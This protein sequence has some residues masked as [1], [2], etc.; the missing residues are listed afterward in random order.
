MLRKRRDIEKGETHRPSSKWT[1]AGEI[2]SEVEGGVLV[3]GVGKPFGHHGALGYLNH[4]LDLILERLGT[5]IQGERGERTL[6]NTQGRWKVDWI[7]LFGLG[8]LESLTLE[9]L[10]GELEGV[11]RDLDRLNLGKAAFLLPG[12]DPYKWCTPEESLRLL[13]ETFPKGGII[14]HPNRKILVRLQRLLQ[15]TAPEEAPLESPLKEEHPKETRAILSPESPPI[16]EKPPPPPKPPEVSLPKEEPQPPSLPIQVEGPPKKEIPPPQPPPEVTISPRERELPPVRPERAP[17]TI[18]FDLWSLLKFRTLDRYITGEVLSSFSLGMA[19]FIL[20]LFLGRLADL[21]GFLRGGSPILI[22]NLVL[23]VTMATLS[24][25]IP[26]AFFFGTI[27]AI[28]RL[29]ADSELV[30]MESLGISLKRM[31]AP[32]ILLGTGVTIVTTLLALY[33]TPLANQALK[34]TL[35]RI[36]T[37]SP[38]MGIKEGEFMGLSRGLWVYCSRTQNRDLK[39]IFL[40]E[41]NKGMTKI[42]TARKGRLKTNPK[43][44]GITLLLKD[45]EILSVKDKDYHLLTFNRYGFLISELSSSLKG[46]TKKELTLPHLLKRLKEDRKRGKGRYLDTLNHF[47][48][49]FSLPFS[50]L[51]FALL[52]LALGTFLPRSEKWTGIVTA[53]GVFLLYYVFLTLSQ[54]LAMKGILPPFMGAWAPD[55]ILG[56]LG[57]ALLWAKSEKVGL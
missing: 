10:K 46:G 53:F 9:D 38:Q 20:L 16:P 47:Y 27:M 19:I 13:I 29:S 33:V 34:G 23:A 11:A 14:A 54:N 50:T 3:I 48:K 26:P 42:V 51:V 56:A 55:I 6:I 15:E 49:R 1:L 30:A 7:L 45:G 43:K 8:D 32:V 22:F 36:V 52:A 2:L 18:P 17:R 44:L 39:G 5:N 28:S 57:V 25:A 24:M 4:T 31:A 40:Y 12:Y 37:S 35:F 41:E 21:L